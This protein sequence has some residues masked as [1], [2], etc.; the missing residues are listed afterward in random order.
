MKNMT[1]RVRIIS[2]CKYDDHQARIAILSGIGG[3]DLYDIWLE[4]PVPDDPDIRTLIHLIEQ[5]V[6]GLPD[7]VLDWLVEDGLPTA[8]LWESL[9]F[10]RAGDPSR[11][12]ARSLSVAELKRL[13]RLSVDK[14]GGFWWQEGQLADAVDANHRRSAVESL[15]DAKEER[16]AP[17]LEF[18]R[19]DG[20][21]T[22]K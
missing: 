22:A 15:S 6:D 8:D 9:R 7:D 18:D 13:I 20:R 14:I 16:L 21:E 19:L 10:D 3:V 1:D 5:G 11:R 17:R 4:R 12:I 2:I